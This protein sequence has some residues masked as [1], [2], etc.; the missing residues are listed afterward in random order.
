MEKIRARIKEKKNIYIHNDISNAALHFKITIEDKLK[1]GDRTG[2]AFDYMACLVMTAFTFE[3][4]VNFLGAKLIPGWKERQPFDDKVK[5]VLAHLK[6]ASDWNKRPY[7]S[8]QSMKDFRDSIAHGK[9]IEI[10]YDQTVEMPA[11]ELERKIDLSGEWQKACSPEAVDA[12][13]EDVEQIWKDLLT[14]AKLSVFDTM[15]RGAGGITVIER[16][17]EA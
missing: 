10:Q 5:E 15:T 17:V 16:I 2:T 1:A 11:D 12:A 7:S 9:P 8:I 13:Y 14:Q 3:A 6:I 4:K